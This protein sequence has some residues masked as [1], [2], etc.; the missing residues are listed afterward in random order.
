[1]QWG[2]RAPN[3]SALP[4]NCRCCSV[5]ATIAMSLN[6]K[7][8]YLPPLRHFP[9]ASTAIVLATIFGDPPANVLALWMAHNTNVLGVELMIVYSQ[10]QAD[11]F[12]R[13]G[14]LRP[15]Y[16]FNSGRGVVIVNVPEIQALETHY[17]NQHFVINNA[18]LRSMGAIDYLG[19]FDVDEFLEIPPGYSMSTYL[20]AALQCH[21]SP[22]D[23]SICTG[24]KFAAVDIGSFMI[25]GYYSGFDFGAKFQFC[26]TGSIDDYSYLPSRAECY[27]DQ[28][29]EVSSTKTSAVVVV[30]CTYNIALVEIYVM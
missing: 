28:T 22:S 4:T 17:Y 25:S 29:P 1:M 9:K 19:S 5:A 3:T 10:K 14:V 13:N 27:G 23:A 6:S 30:N 2:S 24:H 18:L 26:S 11:T 7:I 21:A 16:E 12:D 15:F 8:V 20:Q